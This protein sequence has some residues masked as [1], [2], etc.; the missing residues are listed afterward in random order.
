MSSPL[1]P[2]G[3][4]TGQRPPITQPPPPPNT[5][6]GTGTGQRS[7]SHTNPNDQQSVKNSQT[8]SGPKQTDINNRTSTPSQTARP[9]YPPGSPQALLQRA[10]DNISDVMAK[11]WVQDQLGIILNICE[12]PSLAQKMGITLKVQ[13][14]NTDKVV[15]VFPVI[16]GPDSP[17][18]AH[19]AA[20]EA[21]LQTESA[22]LLKQQK[23]QYSPKDLNHMYRIYREE[24]H[25]TGEEVANAQG[26]FFDWESTYNRLLLQSFNRSL[27]NNGVEFNFYRGDPDPSQRL[28]PEVLAELG[29]Q[30]QRP[31]QLPGDEGQLNNP[32]VE[33]R[34]RATPDDI[35]RHAAHQIEDE[36]E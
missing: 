24:I 31:P 8:P 35:Q 28:S 27:T 4:G 22:G 21:F 7:V 10:E 29:R 2:P 14:P 17:G 36:E 12:D 33:F 6:T 11:M 13:L 30:G 20:Y 5:G 19:Q 1:P 3:Q 34:I 18:P 32:Q 9:Q 25:T 23:Q 15:Q 26:Q 16:S